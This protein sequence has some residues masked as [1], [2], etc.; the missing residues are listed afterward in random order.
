M[1]PTGANIAGG[2]CMAGSER[3]PEDF[4]P[5]PK[6]VTEALLEREKFIGTIWEPACGD[7]AMSK[8]IEA[9]G[10]SVTSS[11]LIDRGYGW[12][13]DFMKFTDASFMG[14]N[15]ITN[16]PYKIATEFVERALSLATNKVCM[17]LKLQFLEGIKRNA[18]FVRYPPK[19]IYMFSKR[20][21]FGVGKSPL[22][23][24]CWFVWDLKRT[25]KNTEIQWII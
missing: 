8:V 11:D 7:G 22:M 10:Y 2:S 3:R 18:L 24:H 21:A 13:E 20:I 1:K 23:N 5:T 12:T 17:L 14:S 16:P 19:T 6:Y 9:A 4:Y 15:I 25:E